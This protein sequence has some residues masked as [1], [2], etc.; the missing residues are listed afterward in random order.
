MRDNAIPG[1]RI[2]FVSGSNGP[3]LGLLEL[4]SA[5]FQWTPPG[6]TVGEAV[7]IAEDETRV[8]TGNPDDAQD[9]GKYVVVTRTSAGGMA[10]LQKETVQLLDVFNNLWGGSNFEDSVLP[11]VRA[12]MCKTAAAVT[13]LTVWTVPLATVTGGLTTV[14]GASG[15]GTIGKAGAFAGWCA[16]GLCEVRTSGGVLREVVY[17]ESRT[18]D[19]LTVANDGRGRLGTSPG[20]GSGTDVC[21]D[22]SWVMS[23]VEA[24]AGGFLTD[25]RTLGEE[26]VPGLTFATGPTAAAGHAIGSLGAGEAYGLWVERFPSDVATYLERVILAYEFVTGGVTYRGA[27]RGLWRVAQTAVERVEVWVGQDAAPDKD[28]DPDYVGTASP[29][30]TGA[31][32]ADHTYYFTALPR[33]KWNVRLEDDGLS[34]ATIHVDAEGGQLGPLPEGPDIVQVVAQGEGQAEVRA[35]YYA[36]REGA[37]AG[38]VFLYRA[39]WWLLYVRADGEDPVPGDPDEP[40]V[41]A[42]MGGEYAPLEQLRAAIATHYLEEQPIRVMV[43]TRRIDLVEVEGE[44]ELQE[45]IRDSENVDVY[46]IL[47]E[48]FSGAAVAPR[49]HLGRAWSLQRD[50][51]FVERTVYVDQGKNIRFE[52]RDGRTEFWAASTLIW[53]I[54]WSGDVED[55]GNGL[56]TVF[57]MSQEEVDVAATAAAAI[58]VGTW[59]SEEKTIYVNVRDKRRMIIDVLGGIIRYNNASDSEAVTG[60]LSDSPAWR[61]WGH[62]CFQV[63][64]MTG[65]GYGTAVEVQYGGLVTMGVPWRQVSTEGECL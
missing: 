21:Y 55:E 57:A 38:T 20:A 39:R 46:G 65:E 4:G 26:S 43:R 64:R 45:Q 32:A 8:V 48:W 1:V 7:E 5:G 58:E 27:L 10:A 13:G 17:Y 34:T 29:I 22:V 60:T 24:P 36:N 14:L 50:E 33:N 9:R 49:G 53:C 51:V 23:A 54:H 28:E 2:D 6:G 15:A 52:I 16:R 47:A 42:M 11:R 56:F 19:I 63:W 59:T 31:L 37:T 18:S 35:V 25:K 3:G 30:E 44:E 40:V 12:A 41:S 61:K 62:T